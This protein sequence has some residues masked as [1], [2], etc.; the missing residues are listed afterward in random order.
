M[1]EVVLARI[2]YASK[3]LRPYDVTLPVNKIAG[4]VFG[5]SKRSGPV[6]R[7]PY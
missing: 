7:P 5:G 4:L 6:K 3:E 1:R 2:V